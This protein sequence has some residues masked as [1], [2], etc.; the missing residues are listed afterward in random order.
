MI[1][2]RA[3]PVTPAPVKTNLW[4]IR[5]ISLLLMLQGVGLLALSLVWVMQ[6]DWLQDPVLFPA[7]AATAERVFLGLFLLPVAFL[8][9]LAA[10]G[11]LFLQRAAWLTAM[12]TQGYILFNG[13]SNYFAEGSTLRESHLLYGVLLSSILMVLYLNSNDVRQTFSLR[14]SA[15]HPPVLSE[16][17]FERIERRLPQPPENRDE[18]PER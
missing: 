10:V 12:L 1:T 6:V 9:L 7:E 17:E 14:H 13:L 5:L 8:L 2:S 15:L 3:A 11:F 16:Q 4:P 18:H